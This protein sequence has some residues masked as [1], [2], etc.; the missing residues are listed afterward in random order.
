MTLDQLW[1]NIGYQWDDINSHAK[2]LLDEVFEQDY[3]VMNNLTDYVNE[4]YQNISR[5]VDQLEM[6]TYNA[7]SM[8]R[9][10]LINLIEAVDIRVEGDFRRLEDIF[11][12]HLF[13]VTEYLKDAVELIN[14]TAGMDYEYVNTEI[15][16][17]TYDINLELDNLQRQIDAITGIGESRVR[18]L[19]D[20]AVT[21][22]WTDTLLTINTVKKNLLVYIDS[23]KDY[24]DSE[25]LA[26]SADI[27]TKLEAARA[28]VD[29]QAADIV[30]S[31]DA[32]REG[33]VAYVL[34]RYNAAKRYT[35]EQVELA[36]TDINVV[37][38]ELKEELTGQITA[39]KTDLNAKRDEIFELLWLKITNTSL[40]ITG[41]IQQVEGRINTLT[42]TGN[43]RA[44]FFNIFRSNPE[45]SFLQ[46]L[47]RDEAKFAEFKPYWQALFTR[48]MGED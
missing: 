22:L 37:V 6:K 23:V 7:L 29:A 41:Q 2:L 35:D 46:V 3:F 42:D 27:D 30:A 32:L 15:Y 48:V 8:V 9:L 4:L 43:W 39:L 28:Y 10:A 20:D 24:V 45:L 14:E 19:I 5:N 38:D 11:N 26:L 21:D 17:A 40:A 25:T 12:T 1:Q 16:W 36:I 18:E 31:V 44:G 33:M 47:L 34:N 13:N